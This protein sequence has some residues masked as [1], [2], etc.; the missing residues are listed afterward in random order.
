M[1]YIIILFGCS[2]IVK[3]FNEKNRKY[4]LHFNFIAFSYKT[5]LKVVYYV[6]YSIFAYINQVP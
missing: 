2:K 5:M 6:N 1:Y 3:L 4:L